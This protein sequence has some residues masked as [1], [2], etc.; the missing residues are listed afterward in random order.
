MSEDLLAVARDDLDAFNAGDWDRL[1]ELTATDSV[2]V[3]PATGRRVEGVDAILELNKEWKAAFPD[4]QGTVTGE[5]ACDDRVV[6]EITWSG[7]HDGPLSVPGGG[8]IE[9]TGR[10][11]E[12]PACQITWV[13]DGK[14]K[15]AHHY[16]DLLGMMAQLGTVSPEALAAH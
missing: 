2:Y 3:E 8:T 14:L 12:T 4:A 9:P 10:H 5:F 7:T 13:E 11:M 6:M 16:F 1:R 15:E